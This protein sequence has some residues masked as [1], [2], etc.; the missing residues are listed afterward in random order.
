MVTIRRKIGIVVSIT[1][2]ALYLVGC[3]ATNVERKTTAGVGLGAL[4]GGLMSGDAGGAAAGAAAGGLIGYAIGTDQDRYADNKVLEQERL[5]LKKEQTA[6]AKA[7]ITNDPKTAYRPDS[8][9]DLVGTTWRIISI[10]GEHPF[11]EYHSVITTF[12]TNSKVTTLVIDEKG[13]TTSVAETYQLVDD[14]MVVTGEQ[15]DQK[16]VVDGKYS[17]QDGTFIFVTPVYR[18]VA[19]KVD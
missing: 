2:I 1:C 17:V 9:N 19:E 15:D 7:T 13:S 4:A 5:A 16:Y 8:R 12:Q 11:P 18:I 3:G 6:I 10:E 14:V